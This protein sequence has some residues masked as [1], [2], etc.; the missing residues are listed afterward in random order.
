VAS[1]RIYERFGAAAATETGPRPTVDEC[2][3]FS[4]SCESA[5]PKIRV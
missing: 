3:R 1:R 4:Y 2:A 5:L